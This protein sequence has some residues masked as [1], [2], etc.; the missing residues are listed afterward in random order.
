MPTKAKK[1]PEKVIIAI[2]ASKV[3]DTVS[4][5]DCKPFEWTL[6]VVQCV[7][8]FLLL[9]SCLRLQNSSLRTHRQRHECG[10]S[11]L[12]THRFELR[13]LRVA[14]TDNMA[15]IHGRGGKGWRKNGEIKHRQ[16]IQKVVVLANKK[17]NATPTPN[18]IQL[19]NCMGAKCD[20]QRRT[21]IN[22][23][24]LWSNF[25]HALRRAACDVIDVCSE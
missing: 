2:C 1:V 24:L 17:S 5:S 10:C 4:E 21:E 19:H 15:T 6:L 23:H 22:A 3:H 25:L 16:E 7:N 8:L 14:A 18:K 20:R 9:C 13:G 11:G 12:L